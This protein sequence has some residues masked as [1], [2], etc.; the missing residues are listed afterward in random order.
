MPQERSLSLLNQALF[1]QLVRADVEGSGAAF[2][3]AL[4][5]NPGETAAIR[6]YAYYVNQGLLG[7]IS[8]VQQ[9][10]QDAMRKKRAK[11]QWRRETKGRADKR[12]ENAIAKFRESVEAARKAFQV[13]QEE[14]E[15]ARKRAKKNKE[16]P[17]I[18]SE[19]KRKRRA[20]KERERDVAQA[21]AKV[22]KAVMERDNRQ[23]R[24][25][26][27]ETSMD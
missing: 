24:Q 1:L 5:E 19:Y 23:R 25:N 11:A 26:A 4:R 3:E 21:Q 22:D 15:S 12:I 14:Y 2:A 13:A 18:M 17:E 7:C 6:G 8:P 9:R 10:V 27:E 20:M 16:D